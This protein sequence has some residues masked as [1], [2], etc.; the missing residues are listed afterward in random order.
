YK[1]C[2]RVSYEIH[3]SDL[4]N[5]INSV[6]FNGWLTD[7]DISTG[8]PETKCIISLLTPKNEFVN[9]NIYNVD[10]KACF[11]KFKGRAGSKLFELVPVLP[12]IELNKEDKR[13]VDSYSVVDK[14][15]GTN[16]ATMD[17]KDFE[18][19]IRELFDKEFCKNDAEI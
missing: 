13:F 6:V 18:N 15:D 2:L 11:N 16:I 10:P 7:I 1:L 5:S 4:S 9:V 14:I 17:W 19:L 3:I 12:I 8:N